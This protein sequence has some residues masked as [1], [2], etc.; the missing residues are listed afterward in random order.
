MRR[1]GAGVWSVCSACTGGAGACRGYPRRRCATSYLDLEAERA[2]AL[3]RE[4]AQRSLSRTQRRWLD[5]FEQSVNAGA[6]FESSQQPNLSAAARLLGKDRS[7]AQRANLELQSCSM[8][9]QE[10]L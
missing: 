1:N 2:R 4:R 10:R 6:I 9:E 5:A 8:R 3:A 7:S